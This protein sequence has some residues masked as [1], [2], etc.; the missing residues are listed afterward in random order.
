MVFN[1]DSNGDDLCTLADA[2]AGSND[3]SFR[4]SQKALFAN[5]GM[6]Q[7]WAAI[8]R[9]SGGWI[10]DD[11]NNED[12]PEFKTALVEGQ[13]FYTLP[14]DTQELHAVGYKD[15]SDSWHA[16]SP[17]T[18]EDINARGSDEAEFQNTPGNPMWYRPVANGLKIYP[19]SDSDRAEALKI[20]TTR[21][22][23]KFTPS[24]TDTSPGFDSMHH[25]SVAVF[26]AYQYAKKNTLGNLPGLTTDWSNAL[27][28]IETHYRKK[29]KEMVPPR[30]KKRV[31][32]RYMEQFI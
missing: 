32:N 12:L 23:V 16:L 24:T 31:A 3:T 13:Q 26:M 5:W 15:S 1:G 29:F 20:A 19:A 6:R 25:E 10:E 30:V 28:E 8:Y 9:F 17:I 14:S 18:L 7:I 21:D 27:A 11:S 22:I 4:L 2:L